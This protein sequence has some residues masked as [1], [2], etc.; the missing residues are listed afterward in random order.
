MRNNLILLV[1]ALLVG[2]IY[3]SYQLVHPAAPT[4]QAFING[5]VLTMDASNSRAQAVLLKGNI[6]SAIGTNDTIQPLIDDNTV[7]HDL[8]GK[9]LIPGFI[10]AHGHFPGSGMAALSVDLNSPPIGKISN[11]GEI[12]DALQQH[13]TSIPKGEWILGIGYDDSL[14]AEHRHPTRKE[15]DLALPDHPVFLWHISGHMGVANS[16]ALIAAG[17]DESSPNP[18]GGVYAK[19]SNGQLTGLLEE[20]AAMAVQALAMDF[21]V[22]DFLTMIQ[23]ASKEYAS[24]GVT[25][26]QSGA[27]EG[28][29][30]Q[31]LA[32][33]NTLGL[34]PQ[35]LE[36]WPIFNTMGTELLDGSFNTNDFEND[37]IH[38][39]AIK[40]I[41]DG[42]IQ[43]YT[44]YLKEPYYVPY[45]N[46]ASYRGY[47]RVPTAELNRWVEDFHRAGYQIAIHGNGDA[48]ID[49]ILTAIELAQQQYPREDSRHIII[50]AQMA[51]EDQLDKM[52]TLGVTPSFF[53]AH[54]Y[55][56]GDRHRDIF[57]GPERAAQM[58]PTASALAK[59]LPFTI[60]LDTP[61]VPMDPLFLVW[62]AVNRLSSSGAV[63]G[64]EQRIAPINALRAVT[65]DAAWQIFQEQTRGSIEI[66]KLAD[67]VILSADPTTQAPETIKDIQVEQT[68]VG[69]I[70]IFDRKK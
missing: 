41:A 13:A 44:G 33:A 12:I 18:E 70:T 27:I 14:L 67:L 68:L 30:T 34:I 22:F 51:R 39:G 38:I 53:V 10:D 29:I 11:M 24:V 5:N 37:K 3:F 62:T 19:D 36:L 2:A 20:N 23:S 50:H 47:P 60:H 49:D 57:M 9:T 43:G 4:S 42:S 45:H 7:I 54:T 63:I 6:I 55:Y 61:V 25:T 32:L 46:D 28:K 69:G 56:W 26:A 58:S 52:K 17:V 8:Q 16:A 40:I 35:R 21:S 15:L 59:E 65:I 1:I 31:G 48:A 64:A 66:G